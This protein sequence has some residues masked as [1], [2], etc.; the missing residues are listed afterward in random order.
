MLHPRSA[1]LI[2]CPCCCLLQPGPADE[3]PDTFDQRRKVETRHLDAQKRRLHEAK[4]RNP[5][6]PAWLAGSRRVTSVRE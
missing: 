6:A 3:D 4:D 1:S 2:E 5:E